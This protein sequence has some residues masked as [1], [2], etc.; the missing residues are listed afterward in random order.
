MYSALNYAGPITEEWP[1]WDAAVGAVAW[2]VHTD[3]YPPA[4][5]DPQLLELLNKP[6]QAVVKFFPN[7]AFAPLYPPRRSIRRD[8][9]LKH[10]FAVRCVVYELSVM[11]NRAG[12]NLLELW[13]QFESQQ[14]TANESDGRFS[15][16]KY[17]HQEN[18][19][20]RGDGGRGR[21]R[22][23]AQRAPINATHSGRSEGRGSDTGH[24][25]SN[26]QDNWRIKRA[27]DI[28]NIKSRGRTAVDNSLTNAFAGLTVT[29]PSDDTP[30]HTEHSE[31]D[32]TVP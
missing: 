16:R 4:A 15:A 24:G 31:L 8:D 18:V 2:V 12:P 13:L 30:A 10:V 25:P 29:K 14:A 22:G 17:P 11:A 23:G 26:T 32:S 20:G 28:R 19:S 7:E 21:G 5:P 6:D 1:E 3:I 9:W 27:V